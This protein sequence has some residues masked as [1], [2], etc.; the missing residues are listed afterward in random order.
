MQ[1]RGAE[2]WKTGRWPLLLSRKYYALIAA[3]MLLD[4]A[5]NFVGINSVEMLFYSAVLNGVLVPHLI[6]LAVLL[7][8]KSERLKRR[9]K[10]SEHPN[11]EKGNGQDGNKRQLQPKG[12]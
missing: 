1:W 5:L 12:G 8:S 7:T 6:V 3:A 11:R 9:G 2:H 10:V 4:L